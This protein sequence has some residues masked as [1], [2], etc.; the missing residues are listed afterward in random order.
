[1]RQRLA[2][3]T[4]F[5]VLIG[6]SQ[7]ASDRIVLIVI[8]TLRRDALSCYGGSRPTPNIDALA[9]RG[10]LLTN[11]MGSFHQTTMSMGAMFTGRT[12]SLESGK[13][14]KKLDWNGRTWCGLARFA[15]PEGEEGCIPASVPT[16]TQ[17]LHA[18]GYWTIGV[19]ANPFLFRPSGFERGFDD[20]VEV[21]PRPVGL[22]PGF[23]KVQQNPVP[24]SAGP[25]NAAVRQS[26]ERRRHDRFF[27]YVHYMDV[28]D[29][30]LGRNDYWTTV[31]EMD[32]TVRRLLQILKHQDL[33][34]GTAIL[35][36]SDHGERLEEQHLVKGRRGHLGNPSFEE[37]LRVPMLVSPSQAWDTSRLLRSQ[38]VF[39]L[40]LNL[41]GLQPQTYQVLEHDELFL[42]ESA[43]R[44]YRRQHW[45]SFI[46][47]DDGTQLLV[48]LRGDP[49]EQRDVSGWHPSIADAH[50]KRIVTLSQ[51]LSARNAP[52][53]EL[54][55]DD[56][57]RLKALGY[58]E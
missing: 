52:P 49:G 21:G 10:Q 45:K 58:L 41:A 40:I 46:R 7:P 11:A 35:L 5:L 28:H 17:L 37:M 15:A 23:S 55:A 29:Y 30:R 39:G 48:D 14:G 1:M 20:W 51:E 27:L 18:A 9:A 44:T 53:T 47:R 34:E 38:D 8:D 26:L 22:G 43:W 24:R 42:T 6:C 12:P 33:L 31:V 36:T 54:S 32:T 13:K 25:V 16:L 19:V 56:R 4:T 2:T 50:R 3:L 57:A